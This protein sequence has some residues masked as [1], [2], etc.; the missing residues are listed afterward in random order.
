MTNFTTEFQRKAAAVIA[1]FVLS[2]T[3]V[4]A[5]VG[6]AHAV[7]AIAAVQVSDRAAA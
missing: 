2:T 1:A 5:A 6:P 7:E 3:F 4:T